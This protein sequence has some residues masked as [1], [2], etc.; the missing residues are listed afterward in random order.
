MMVAN[1][2]GVLRAPR[3]RVFCILHNDFFEYREMYLENVLPNPNDV[4]AILRT[5]AN[6]APTRR[7]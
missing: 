2:R 4:G 6:D 1:P 7:Q 5:A 3:L